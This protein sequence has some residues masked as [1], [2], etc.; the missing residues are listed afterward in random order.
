MIGVES[1]CQLL[2]KLGDSLVK[3]PEIFGAD[4]RPGN[5]V[6]YLLSKASGSKSLDYSLLWSVL[7]N[8]LLPIWPSDRTQINGI[9]VGDAWPL[10]V[11]AD[12]AKKNGDTFPTASI[13]PFHKLTQWLAYS[14]M[15]P[16]ERILGVTWQNAHLGTGLPEYRNGGLFV[17]TGVLKLKPELDIPAPGETLPKFGSTD[18]VI[19]EWRA[20][21]VALLDELHKVILERMGIQLSLAQVLESGSWKA[22]R[23]LAAERRP[24]T[25]SSPILLA[26]DGTLF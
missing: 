4:G 21:T 16:F 11:L 20:M 6:D 14:L 7:Q 25:R 9:P 3:L 5:L 18:D 12:H 15:V 24:K 22:G 17:D 19:V 2:V 1:R 26:G 13:Q 10:Q 8:A 23:E